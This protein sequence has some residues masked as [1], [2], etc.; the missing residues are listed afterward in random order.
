MRGVWII[1]DDY[2]FMSE[3]LKLCSVD[4]D[5]EY[6]RQML[7]NIDPDVIMILFS[8]LLGI[9]NVV[10]VDD[11]KK[12][13]IS[14][15]V[16]KA[17]YHVVSN[18]DESYDDLINAIKLRPIS[19]IVQEFEEESC[20][21]YCIFAKYMQYVV[22]WFYGFYDYTREV[23]I[24]EKHPWIGEL[25]ENKGFESINDKA[26]NVF[27]D[28]VIRARLQGANL[29]DL[30]TVFD[31]Y[32]R[33]SRSEMSLEKY[34]SE[35]TSSKED[36]MNFK[37]FQVRIMLVDVYS[38]LKIESIEKCGKSLEIEF[39]ILEELER[40]ICEE[41]YTLPGD[42]DFRHAIYMK[43]YHSLINKDLLKV[44]PEFVDDE[45]FVKVIKPVNPLFF[46]D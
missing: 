4:K 15:L 38:L 36:I 29:N 14:D 26:R 28:I 43:F 42:K 12:F 37:S 39:A 22:D 27:D 21:A 32:F 7:L 25:E 18:Y 17:L 13:I 6:S 24:E 40:K 10:R 31:K 34:A 33:D 44:L 3:Y 23:S 1:M 41:D 9:L 46:L 45:D 5:R 30:Y 16:R 35:F 11:N 20:L 19:Y 2:D 8:K